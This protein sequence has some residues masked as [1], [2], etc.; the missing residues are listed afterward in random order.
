M[1]SQNETMIKILLGAN[2]NNFSGILHYNID[3]DIN[4]FKMF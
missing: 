4:E 2:E 3:L 1:F